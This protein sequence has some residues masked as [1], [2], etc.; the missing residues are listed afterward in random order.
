M[1]A[2]KSKLKGYETM[3][4]Q[5]DMAPPDAILGLTEAFK[6]D[7]NP[8][9][10]NLGVGVYKDAG[11]STPVLASVKQAE[12]QILSREDTK[13]YFPIDGTPE[14][15]RVVRELIFGG[16]HALVGD[17]R[18]ATAQ[19]PGGTGAL[20]VAADFITARLPGTRVWLSDPTWANHAS[21]F[22]AAGVETASYPYYDAGAKQ[23]DFERMASGLKEIPSTDVVLLH[24][25]CQNPTGMDPTVEQ[26]DRIAAIA[27]NRGWTPLVDFAYQGFAD[28][29]EEDAAGV[30][31]IAEKVPEL[32]VCTSF[33]KNFGLYRERVGAL[34]VIGETPDTTEKALSH[35]KKCIRANYSNPPAH[36]GLIVTAVLQDAALRAA[37]EK[38][39]AEMRERINGMRSLFVDTLKAKGVTRDYSF[40]T[41]QRGMFS[42][43]GLTKEQ[44]AALRDRYS[45]YVVGSGRINVAGMTA[46][47]MDYLCEA[48]ADVL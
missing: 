36:G 28:G 26:W 6:K 23:L 44:V 27:A 4:G 34:T 10:I 16:T 45:I 19:T 5:L 35:V 48:I 38:E 29:L 32:F 41:R 25:C 9:K 42:L 12:E 21:I 43:S 7:P 47:N 8:K 14:Y 20:R 40:L 24:G 30:R 39:V 18:A 17:G 37:W 11:G 2:S 33:S 46:G 1:G 3:F 15:G 22:G 13:S 31:I